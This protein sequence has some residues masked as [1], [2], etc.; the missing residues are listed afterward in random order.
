LNLDGPE[1]SR[2]SGPVRSRASTKQSTIHPDDSVSNGGYRHYR[3]RESDARSRSR[4]P[5]NDRRQLPFDDHPSA[6]PSD[7][8]YTSASRYRES[9]TRGRSRAPANDR[10]QPSRSGYP[11]TMPGDFGYNSTSS[12]RRTASMA[13]THAHRPQTRNEAAP[14]VDQRH[15]SRSVMHPRARQDLRSTYTYQPAAPDHYSRR[16]R[17]PTPDSRA[18]YGQAGSGAYRSSTSSRAAS[19]RTTA[20]SMY[21][22]TYDQAGSGA[23]RSPTSSRAG[24]SRTTAG[25]MYSSTYDQVM[26][27]ARRH[28]G[29][30]R[31]PYTPCARH[32]HLPPPTP[33]LRGRS[34]G[35]VPSILALMN[36]AAGYDSDEEFEYM[37]S[38]IS[39]L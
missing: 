33:M 25:S 16:S 27:G 10:H 38:R 32:S 9:D 35:Y 39:G 1:P 19:G 12:T 14:E 34:G 15:H 30:G 23:H 36:A 13:R 3:P 24:P 7:S 4:A 18:S 17:A 6:R 11:P 2:A 29:S 22:S 20:G 37:Q 5:T 31:A 21:S 28:S 8:G 26:A